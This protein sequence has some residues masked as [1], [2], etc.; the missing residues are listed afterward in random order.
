MTSASKSNAG[1][2]P[3]WSTTGLL[4]GT[5]AAAN[6]FYQPHIPPGIAVAAWFL[7]L[8][9]ALCLLTHPIGSRIAILLTGLFLAVPCFV[10]APPLVRCVLMCCSFLPCAIVALQPPA[11]FDNEFRARIGF[12]MT[13]LGTREVKRRP[14][15]FEVSSLFQLITATAVFVAMV[16]TV[17]SISSAGIPLLARWLAGGIMILAF[18]AM[19]TTFHSLLTAAIGLV[20]P[21]LF[22]AP[23]LSKSL[24]EFW[25]KRWNPGASVIF[26]KACFE[27]VARYSTATAM[28]LT[29]LS[30]AVGH[31]LLV[32]LGL[33]RWKISLTCGAFFFVQ[34]LFIAIERKL[35]VRRW[36]PAAGWAWTMAVLAITSPLF[37]ESALQII[38]PSWGASNDLLSPTIGALA[39]IICGDVFFSLFALIAEP[40]IPHAET[41]S[42]ASESAGAGPDR[43]ILLNRR[44]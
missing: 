34:P 35:G 41:T 43:E 17:K 3:V 30:S 33:G 39:I 38:E 40:G 2:F 42:V 23:H 9:L 13:W 11:N 15:T 16:A 10:W 28:F 24:S 12:L 20:S 6:P 36:R 29:F 8:T 18:A 5:L 19:S 7:D 37:V 32:F 25:T 21:G 22:Q 4:L 14:R 44:S 31:A 27:P 1:K 26:R